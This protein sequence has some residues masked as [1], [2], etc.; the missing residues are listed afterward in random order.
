MSRARRLARR[1][2]V[3]ALYSWQL[4]DE[5]LSDI[6]Q[7]F[8]LEQN[9]KDVDLAYFKELLHQVPKYL[10]EIDAQIET[11]LDRPFK[12]LDPIECAVMRLAVYE[13]MHRLDVPYRVV[14][15]EAVELTKTFGAEDGFKYVNSIV[16]GLAKQL[17]K[18]EVDAARR[19]RQ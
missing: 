2:A 19:P 1:R 14:I 6:E 13:L 4:S 10:D 16:D 5:A 11:K 8:L 18:A 7:Q 3:Q 17:R 15:N 9:M 12:E